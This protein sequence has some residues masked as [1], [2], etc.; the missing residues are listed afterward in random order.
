MKENGFLIMQPKE[1]KDSLM[2]FIKQYEAGLL[3]ENELK[4]LYES[5]LPKS[6]HHGFIRFVKE[7]L[8]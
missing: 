3:N 7:G 4:N 8:R 5:L 6:Y 1:I 2:D